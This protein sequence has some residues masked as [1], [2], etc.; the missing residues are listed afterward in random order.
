MLL[1][2]YLDTL[3][4]HRDLTRAQAAD[5]MQDL[6]SGRAAPETIAAL[7]IALRMKGESVDEITGMAETMRAFSAQVNVQGP[8]LDTCGTGGDGA[9]TFNISTAAAFVLAAGGARVAKHGNRSVSS[10]SGSA[11]VLEALGVAIQLAPDAVADC[12]DRVGIGFLFA[13]A[14]HPAMRHVMPTRLKLGVRTVFNI[15]GPLT[16]PA[17]ARH[18][19]LGVFSPALTEP[20][21]QVLR[22]LGSER[23]LVVHADGLD[24][25]ALHASTRVSELRDGE[26]TT[27]V[28]T[29]EA[30][31]L[32]SAPLDAIRGGA[33][34]ENAALVQNVLTNAAPGPA[35]DVVLFNAGAGFYVRGEASTLADGVAA[36]RA[37]LVTGHAWET[38]ETL[39]HFSRQHAATEETP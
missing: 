22:Q 18:H 28:I 26:I 35:T 2:T 19:V 10:R 21:A 16:N 11:D 4:N 30:V 1:Q 36:A 32:R 8:L 7:L 23:A 38:V 27:Y 33:P 39:R 24:E 14:Y 25:F 6:M 29:P 15:L 13:P 31:G 5:A 34:D 3:L 12:I 37:V 9:N 17:G 20:L